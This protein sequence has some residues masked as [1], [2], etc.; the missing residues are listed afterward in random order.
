MFKII[1]LSKELSEFSIL[2]K[3]LKKTKNM[4]WTAPSSNFGSAKSSMKISL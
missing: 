4:P 3:A 2:S 1:S